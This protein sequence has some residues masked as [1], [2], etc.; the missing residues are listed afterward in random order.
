M[1]DD[2][3][4]SNNCF[5][6]SQ[7]PGT[8]M[9]RNFR[10]RSLVETFIT[11]S[12]YQRQFLFA[13]MPVFTNGSRRIE[14]DF[15]IIKDGI[16]VGLEIDSEQWH[17]E[18]MLEAEDRLRSFRDNLIDITRV[19]APA[20]DA[21]LSW[22]HSVIDKIDEKIWKIRSQGYA[23]MGSLL[24]PKPVP[25][26]DMR[27]GINDAA[28]SNTRADINLDGLNNDDNIPF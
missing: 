14:L 15:L 1:S 20:Y 22:A 21:S 6:H 25:N 13:P 26:I 8:I 7:H 17:Q 2:Y 24:F 23:A 10:H 3:E 28:V 18:S 9:H 11:E 4:V 16:A 5:G 27:E 12:L 19:K